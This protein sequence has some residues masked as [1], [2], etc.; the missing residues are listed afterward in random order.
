[1]RRA[2]TTILLIAV[3]VPA[4]GLVLVGLVALG[5]RVRAERAQRFADAAAL[6]AVLG[7]PYPQQPGVSV[8]IDTF[9]SSVR[10][11]VVLRASR[12]GGSMLQP[13]ATA[14]ARPITTAD[15]QRGAVLVG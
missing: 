15:G 14:L 11:S 7:R 9:G 10:A 1:M 8:V 3:L 13:S 2:Q 12:L 5:V 4:S 6:S